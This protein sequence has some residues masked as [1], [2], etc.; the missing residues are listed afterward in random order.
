MRTIDTAFTEAMSKRSH[1][2]PRSSFPTIDFEKQT[3]PHHMYQHF[4]ELQV[5][6]ERTGHMDYHSYC[7]RLWDTYM[8]GLAN[9][10]LYRQFEGNLIRNLQLIDMQKVV[11]D[12]IRAENL[13]DAFGQ[14]LPDVRQLIV[15]STGDVSTTGYQD[16]KIARSGVARQFR[17]AVGTL[18]DDPQEAREYLRD[19]T[20]HIVAAAST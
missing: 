16:L 10:Q 14:L 17:K 18:F 13:V 6:V 11:E 19:R 12:D 3:V 20:T 15:W 2:A 5:E 9:E 7:E 1:L 4:F 8:D